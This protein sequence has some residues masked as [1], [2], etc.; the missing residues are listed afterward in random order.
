MVVPRQLVAGGAHLIGM[1]GRENL[2]RIRVRALLIEHIEPDIAALAKR[3]A[4]AD[5][6]VRLDAKHALVVDRVIHRFPSPSLHDCTNFS[7]RRPSCR[8]PPEKSTWRR[9]KRRR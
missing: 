4:K 6:P 9:R 3:L 1:S 7:S 5:R 2:Q 8:R